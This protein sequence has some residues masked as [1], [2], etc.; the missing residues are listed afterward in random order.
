MPLCPDGSFCPNPAARV[1][2]AAGFYCRAG[3]VAPAR[4]LA[5]LALCRAGSTF[6]VLLA[7]WVVALAVLALMGVGYWLEQRRVI[8]LGLLERLQ[9]HYAGR[10]KPRLLA[11]LWRARAA[12]A[13][14][15][16]AGGGGG[17]GGDACAPAAADGGSAVRAVVA[18][19]AAPVKTASD[20]DA[21]ADPGELAVDCSRDLRTFPA[22]PPA[23]RV[24]VRVRDVS[25]VVRKTRQPILRSV[26]CA[27]V[28]GALNYIVGP[29]GGGKTSLL[30][31]LLNLHDASA[32][33]V[34]GTVSITH[35]DDGYAGVGSGTQPQQ[36][37]TSAAPPAPLSRHAQAVAYVPHEDVL[38]ERV[39]AHDALTTAAALRCD[40][41]VSPPVR[42]QRVGELERLL[43]LG[44]T[45]HVRVT[46]LGSEAG[47][48]SGQRRRLALATELLGA[49][50]VILG[51]EVR[52]AGGP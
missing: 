24:G 47:L 50:S 48:S 43:Q 20:G 17:G 37:P 44:S 4:C 7:A 3:S 40:A 49:P 46:P 14:A 41:G 9:E 13:A 22:V 23:A 34:T 19:A 30:R 15:A 2:C 28:P 36:A 12:K 18:S 38:P 26:S 42:R 51:D 16:A 8:R 39:T 33:D 10:L 6:P 32:M 45:K 31:V 11:A 35:G 5:P 1:Q 25:L 52:A 21:G 29:S 27:F